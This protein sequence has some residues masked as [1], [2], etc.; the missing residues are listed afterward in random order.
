MIHLLGN[1]IAAAGSFAKATGQ[2]N[3][4]KSGGS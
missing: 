2:K 3:R 1:N 4:E